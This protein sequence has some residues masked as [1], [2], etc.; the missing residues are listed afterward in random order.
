MEEAIASSLLEGAATTRTKA[1]KMLRE[2]RKPRN[3]AEKM[4]L[5]NYKA[6]LKIRDMKEQK[7]SPKMLIHLQ[8]ILTD[9]TLEDS[10]AVG[11][12]RTIDD[13]VVVEEKST[14]EILHTPPRTDLI[15]QRLEEIC[16]FANERSK[17]FIHPVVKAII[18]HFA[19][20]YLHPF[21]DGN[22]RTAG[23][24]FSLLVYVKSKL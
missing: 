23:A 19:L 2:G 6:I 4:I 11:R 13:N 22:G 9:E 16:N 7:L 18:L 14:H 15:K 1:K 5:N 24:I 20:G 17:P 21:A 12:F 10:S 8:S 3:N